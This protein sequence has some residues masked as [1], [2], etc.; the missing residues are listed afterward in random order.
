MIQT[1][2]LDLFRITVLVS[3]PL[4]SCIP[5]MSP[6]TRA[7]A[8][9]AALPPLRWMSDVFSL[10]QDHVM[11]A[12]I[13]PAIPTAHTAQTLSFNQVVQGTKPTGIFNLRC[14]DDVAKNNPGFLSPDFPCFKGN[15]TRFLSLREGK[16]CYFCVRRSAK[17]SRRPGKWSFLTHT[18][19][20]L[21]LKAK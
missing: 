12:C 14:Q 10:W 3:V 18:Y 19:V 13:L 5:G 6:N 15:F 1:R 16:R 4:D 2:H 17:E 21:P 9:G 8:P 7:Q 20:D 11:T